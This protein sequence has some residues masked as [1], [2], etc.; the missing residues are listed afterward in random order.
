[1]FAGSD[2]VAFVHIGTHKTGTTSFQRWASQNCAELARATGLAYYEGLF[3]PSHYEIPM[4]CMRADR[5][6]P[7]RVWR[8]RWWRPGWRRKAERHIRDQVARDVHSL[9]ISAEALSY[10]RHPDEV[11]RL[12]A[13][14]KPRQITAIAVLRKPSSFLRSYREAMLEQGFPPSSDRQSFAYVADDSWLVDYDA[15]L[16]VY[17]QKLG[18]DHVVA[19]D[20]E[21]ELQRY[22]SII[23]AILEAMGFDHARAP[24]WEDFRTNVSGWALLNRLRRS[25]LLKRLRRPLRR[26]R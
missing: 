7:Q 18:A 15:L 16:G 5:D 22:G 8:P 1:L 24:G 10:M 11:A 4:L 21:R 20:Y 25:A 26:Q 13:L 14:L 9:L 17:R 3:G 19:L 6:M 2:S 12:I 23:P